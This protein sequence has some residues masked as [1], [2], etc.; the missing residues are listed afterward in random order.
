METINFIGLL[1]LTWLITTGAAPIQF[2][3]EFIGIAENPKGLIRK[4]AS[5]LFNCDLCL[6]FWI[7][8]LF[9]QNILIAC[10]F[11]LSCEIFGRILDKLG[12]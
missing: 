2:I 7:G 10:I 11:S 8:L 12:F 1:C 5:K 3:K 6:G 9:Y 4:I